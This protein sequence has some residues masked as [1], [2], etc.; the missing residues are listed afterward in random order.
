LA[1]EKVKEL[2]GNVPVRIAAQSYLMKFYGS[3]GFKPVE[4]EYMW[5]GI[6]HTDMLLEV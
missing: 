1:L 4:E 3:F 6:L 2:Y 5:D